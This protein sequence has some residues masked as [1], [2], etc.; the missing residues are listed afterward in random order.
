MFAA[1]SFIIDPMIENDVE[2]GRINALNINCEYSNY[3]N[4]N[5]IIDKKYS[6][7]GESEQ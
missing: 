6:E 7:L 3:T 2:K 4:N 5:E 1:F